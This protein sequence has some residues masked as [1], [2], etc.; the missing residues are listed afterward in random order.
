MRSR[1]NQSYLSF[2]SGLR[3]KPARSRNEECSLLWVRRSPEPIPAIQ[4]LPTIL[5]RWPA[6]ENRRRELAL[7]VL[8]SMT[9]LGVHSVRDHFGRPVADP[10]V[11]CTEWLAPLLAIE[12]QILLS[13][14]AE[15]QNITVGIGE[16]H[17]IGPFMVLRLLEHFHALRSEILEQAIAG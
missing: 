11:G 15:P 17:L 9:H 12:W 8:L 3:L 4:F 2:R 13:L 1:A 7:P 5:R 16:H 6:A 14:R 10:G